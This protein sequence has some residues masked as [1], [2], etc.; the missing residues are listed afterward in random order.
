M[1]T[2]A[3][4]K[5]GILSLSILLSALVLSGCN[6]DSSPSAAEITTKQLTANN[7]KISTVLVDDVVQTSL[8]TN[9]TLSFTST[10][11]TTTNGGPVWPTTGTWTFIDGTGRKIK[12]DDNVEITII[13]ISDTTLKIS[14]TWAK[15]IFGSGRISSVAGNHVFTFVK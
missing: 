3:I 4:H 2:Y 7:W 9:M 8:F 11:Y 10:N 12:R 13:E 1:R 5:T 6:G 14:L 15:N